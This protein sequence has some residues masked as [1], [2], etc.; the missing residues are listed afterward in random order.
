MSIFHR[1]G[2]AVLAIAIAC[3]TSSA[4]N[5]AP[6]GVLNLW[7][8]ASEE[9]IKGYPGA[10]WRVEPD[11]DP[12]HRS[13]RYVS[14]SSLDEGMKQAV[15][16][17][18]AGLYYYGSFNYGPQKDCRGFLAP[19]LSNVG[20]KLDRPQPPGSIATWIADRSRSQQKAGPAVIER[21]TAGVLIEANDCVLL[22]MHPSARSGYEEII[23]KNRYCALNMMSS[24]CTPNS[25][26]N[27]E[28]KKP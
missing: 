15:M 12:S 5:A 11:H 3:A 9:W 16:V 14:Q 10:N 26:V 17:T 7:P 19:K 27:Q 23:L 1:S 24:Q 21:Y 2:R 18:R 25:G 13:I 28:Q 6:Q 4:V 22:I 20:Y 8:G